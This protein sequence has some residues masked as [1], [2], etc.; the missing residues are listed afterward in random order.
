M[1][2]AARNNSITGEATVD[3]QPISWVRDGSLR[4]RPIYLLAHG[5]GAPQTSD[6]MAMV[7]AGLVGRGITVVRFNFPY[8]ERAVREGKRR[9][10]DRPP[11][12]LQ[13][14]VAMFDLVNSWLPK[15]MRQAPPHGSGWQVHGRAH[16]VDDDV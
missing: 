4:K 13:T 9:P 1:T 3:G 14:C 7:A 15:W 12:L 8:M 6:F 2:G 10:P 11:R 5:A 16:D